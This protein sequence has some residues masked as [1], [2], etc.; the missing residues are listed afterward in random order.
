MRTLNLRIETWIEF[1]NKEAEMMKKEVE[2]FLFM[3][4]VEKPRVMLIL[5][6]DITLMNK[7]MTGTIRKGSGKIR[8]WVSDSTFK[9]E[10][11][12]VVSHKKTHF[13]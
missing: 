1:G 3:R 6:S 4:I 10:I 7:S 9:T 11:Q 8:S 2:N 12:P 13:N 5:I